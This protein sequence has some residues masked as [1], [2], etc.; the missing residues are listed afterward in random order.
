MFKEG[1]IF[2][3]W[4]IALF[5]VFSPMVCGIEYPSTA[6]FTFVLLLGIWKS[7]WRATIQSKV[8]LLL[9]DFFPAYHQTAYATSFGAVRAGFRTEDIIS[10]NF[11]ASSLPEF[12]SFLP[13]IMA[14]FYSTGKS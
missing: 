6:I 2:F 13:F 7:R 4:G 8:F 3:L 1:F 11:S 5:I 10:D 12:P 14:Y 9:T